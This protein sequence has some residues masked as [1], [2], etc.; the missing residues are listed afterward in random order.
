MQVQTL[1]ELF[2]HAVHEH[3]PR[4]AVRHHDGGDWRSITYGQLGRLVE[5][6][7]V[8]LSEV[9][10]EAGDRVALL[11]PNGP[12]W[13]L[14]DFAMLHLGAITIPLPASSP[15]EEV[16]GILD[17]TDVEAVFAAT[18]QA[19]RTIAHCAEELPQLPTLI[20]MESSPQDGEFATGSQ[21]LG[22]EEIVTV[23][24]LCERGRRILGEEAPQAFD[25]LWHAVEPTDV[26]TRITAHPNAG[27][28]AH[29]RARREPPIVGRG[30]THG[31]LVANTRALSSLLDLEPGDRH[32]S[33]LS[34]A[35]PLERDAGHFAAYHGGAEVWF[36]SPS[37]TLG[38]DLEACQP[39][40]MVGTPHVYGQLKQAIEKRL[41]ASQPTQQRLFAW[42]LSVG[43]ERLQAHEEEGSASLGLRARH[44]LAKRLVLGQLRV[45]TGLAAIDAALGS[46]APLDPEV[47]RWFQAIGVPLLEGY[48][49]TTGRLLAVDR[50]ED[51]R[52][53]SAGRPLPGV[54]VRIDED[55]VS[56]PGE[57]EVL[58]RG[59]TVVGA[60]RGGDD[61][62]RQGPGWTEDGW[63]RTGDVGRLDED[64]VL[65]ITDRQA[66]DKLRE[67]EPSSDR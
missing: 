12:K 46:P 48:A 25:E 50:P 53:G 62:E 4:T 20:T 1:P 6:T 19:S 9:G 27:K 16:A 21:A 29:D 66:T 38:Q 40:L 15:A 11:A 8:G 5:E 32:L 57:G 63:R 33:V 17:E 65:Y 10:I 24:H 22:L 36:A 44:W 37:R 3:G 60:H 42:A 67:T 52:P 28:E 56:R 47:R 26:A 35:Q 54:E 58:V 64:G 13:V 39:N 2:Q 49:S 55:A 41:A 31:A 45:Q 14:A 34:L 43:E 30:L 61:P 51:P 23:D 7:T 18:G 59:P